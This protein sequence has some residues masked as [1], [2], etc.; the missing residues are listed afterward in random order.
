LFEALG[1]N[2]PDDGLLV[3]AGEDEVVFVVAEMEPDGEAKAEL[4]T[5]VD[6][7][8]VSVDWAGVELCADVVDAKEV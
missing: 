6:V 3:A 2:G 1:L 7:S 4:D 5:K 8:E